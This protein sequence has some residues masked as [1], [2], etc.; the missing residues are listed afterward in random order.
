MGQRTQITDDV[1]LG[2]RRNGKSKVFKVAKSKHGV[3]NSYN[4]DK[5]FLTKGALQWHI[6]RAKGK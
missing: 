1:G 5:L 3:M 4:N 2:S 6:L